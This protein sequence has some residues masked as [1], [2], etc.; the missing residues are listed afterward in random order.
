MLEREQSHVNNESEMHTLILITDFAK[1]A[2]I[3]IRSKAASKRGSSV[4][5]IF[6]F[7]SILS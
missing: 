6:P 5:H 2:A 4:R 3:I 1:T 7:R